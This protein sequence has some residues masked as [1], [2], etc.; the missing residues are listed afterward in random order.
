MTHDCLLSIILI[1]YNGMKDTC[2]LMDTIPTEMQGLEVIVVDNGSID[3]EADTIKQRYPWAVVV[4]SQRNLGF[5]GGNNLGIKNAHGQYLL[6]INNDTLLAYPGEQPTAAQRLQMLIDFLKQHPEVGIVCPM[7]RHTEQGNPIQW[8]GYTPLTSLTLR[9]AS[10]TPNA[11]NTTHPHPTP[12]AHGAAMLTSSEAVSR[13]GMMPEEYFLYYEEIDW[14]LLFRRAGYEIW[15]EPRC[16]IYHKESST[17]GKGSAMQTY[18]L[19]RNR[20][21]FAQRN[22][23]G[24]KR[25]ASIAYQMCIASPLHWLAYAAKGQ[26]DWRRSIERAVCDF[27]KGRQGKDKNQQS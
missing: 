16:T 1:N 13:V 10:V 2:E 3:N 24:A 8:V 14:S 5:A 21:I 27:V 6:F 7:L 26:G 17:T 15:V 22:L 19:T 11:D 23:H 20:L 4:R 12:Y 9:N 18:Y 25:I